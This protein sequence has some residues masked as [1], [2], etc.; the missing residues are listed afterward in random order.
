MDRFQSRY[1]FISIFLGSMAILCVISWCSTSF[2][3]YSL[4]RFRFSPP[5]GD[6]KKSFYADYENTNVDSL[7]LSD[8]SSNISKKQRKLTKEE[9][10][11]RGL[12]KARAS[13]LRAASDRNTTEYESHLPNAEVYHNPAAFYRS[14]VEMEK[15]FRVYVYEEGVLPLV[16]DGPCKDVY[17]VEGRFIHEIERGKT[18]F[19]TRDPLKAHVYFMPFSV[20]FLVKYL[21]QGHGDAKPLKR[22]V[23]DYVTT[24]SSKYPFWNRSSGADHFMLACHDWGPL[25]SKSNPHLFNTSIRVLCNANSSEGFNPK[26]DA[27]LPEIKLYGSEINPKL[28]LSKTGDYSQRPYLAFFAGGLHGPIRPILLEHWK[29]RDPDMP[30]HEYLPKNLN[31]YDFMLQS[32]FCLCPSGYEVASPRV[33]ESIY[34]ECVPVILSK[35]FVLPLSDVLRWE[36]FSVQVDV[37]E[38]PRLKEILMSVSEEKYRWLRRNLQYVRRHFVLN[39][40]PERF[41][42]FHTTLHSIWLRRINFALA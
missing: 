29:H 18:R 19:R 11:E 39:Q 37:S 17:A 38:I 7:G 27:S 22:F 36:T 6:L 41:D 31:F 3:D 28:T 8:Q 40:P 26:K 12:A 15:R 21:Y 14:Y 16:H 34:A 42:A 24:I 5:V 9:E 20:T 35:N 4:L 25:V 1:N 30:V 2:F 33:I 13:I 23:S 10:L 32:K